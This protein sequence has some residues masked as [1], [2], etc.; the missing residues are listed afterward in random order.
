[1]CGQMLTMRMPPLAFPIFIPWKNGAFGIHVSGILLEYC[2]RYFVVTA[3]HVN[4]GDGFT[5]QLLV[6]Q[7][8]DPHSLVSLPGQSISSPIPESRSRVHDRLDLAVIPIQTTLAAGLRSIGATAIGFDDVEVPAVIPGTQL[9]FAGYPEKRQ[10]FY[11]F[12]GG[13]MYVRPEMSAI[14]IK[15]I[16][17]DV[18]Q[19]MGYPVQ[20]HIVG[21][22]RHIETRPVGI[23]P[24]LDSPNGMSGGSAW[25]V[26]GDTLQFAGV[27]TR[28]DPDGNAGH[29]IATR[30]IALP[31]MLKA[32][33]A[34][35]EPN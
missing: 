32:A 14:W 16:H 18:A 20:T 25:L 4:D 15:Q 34:L 8:P 17:A 1:M 19:G 10:H 11:P 23:D 24:D 3:A 35:P 2:K 29:L 6:A 9:V 28:W 13:T 7:S 30:A 31:E 26:D 21:R 27:I 12:E 5:D 22:F 33:L